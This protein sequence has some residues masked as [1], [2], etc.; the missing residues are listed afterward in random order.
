MKQFLAGMGLSLGLGLL[1]AQ[2]QEPVRDDALR[3]SMVSE[4]VRTDGS[5]ELCIA[6]AP[7]GP[8][9]ENL[10][11]A[12]ETLVYDASG[13]EIWSG[14]WM[15]EKKRVQF[16][17]ALPQAQTMLIRATKPFVVNRSSGARIH[18]SKPMELKITLK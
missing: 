1:S 16:S 8:C 10:M 18:Q 14:L 4:S 3:F 11:A 12:Y 17:K 2:T 13:K 6:R 9:I 7:Q 15:G 5:F